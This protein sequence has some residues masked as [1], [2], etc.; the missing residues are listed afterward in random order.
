MTTP[1]PSCR[2][3]LCQPM[4]FQ[5]STVGRNGYQHM[6]FT[7]LLLQPTAAAEEEEQQVGKEE[8]EEKRHQEFLEFDQMIDAR[9]LR[10]WKCFLCFVVV[11]Y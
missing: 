2:L 10:N 7:A 1:P 4:G 5:Y 8:E 9:P 6:P 3:D 11:N